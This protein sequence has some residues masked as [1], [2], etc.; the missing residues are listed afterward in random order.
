MANERKCLCCG[1]SYDYCPNCG[2]SSTPWKFNFDSE[3]CRDLFNAVS[4]YNMKLIKKDGVKEVLD[5]YSISDYTMYNDNV[6]SVLDKISPK[7]K[8]TDG[9][10]NNIVESNEINF[11]SS[12]GNIPV[13]ED[14]TPRRRMRSRFFE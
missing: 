5:K 10:E 13:Y 7:I 12:E 14:E 1:K 4:G 2:K 11:S 3:S 6:K 8:Y 9:K